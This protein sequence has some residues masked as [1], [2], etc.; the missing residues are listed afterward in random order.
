MKHF[1]PKFTDK[2]LKVS[3]VRIHI[4]TSFGGNLVLLNPRIG[5]KILDKFIL[6]VVFG[7]SF[8]HE[9]FK[10]FSKR[11]QLKLTSGVYIINQF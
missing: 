10:L 7:F 11:F 1:W 5:F 3:V 4:N 6:Y 2:K 8:V 9:L